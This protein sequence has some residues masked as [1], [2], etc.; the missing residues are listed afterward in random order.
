[1]AG[2]EF[3]IVPAHTVPFADVEAVFG[4]RGDPATCWC[5][6]FKIPGSDWRESVPE[7]RARLADQVADASTDPGLIAYD[8]DAPV[9]WVA[10]EPRSRLPRLRT[11]RIVADGSAQPDLDD[12]GVWALTC[13][14][15]PRAHRRR[16]VAG[17]LARAAVEHAAAHGA[18]VVEGYAIDPSAKSKASAA[19][20]YVGTVSMFVG[21]G[22]DVVARPTATRVV[23]QRRLGG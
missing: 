11:S 19:E 4:T 23:M 18:R 22:F 6:W 7:L 1:M 17:G 14:V 5:Q 2:S 20:L 8:G 13:F 15:V 21:A 3:R 16:G 10:I 12:D 9:G